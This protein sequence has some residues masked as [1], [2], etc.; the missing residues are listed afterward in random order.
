MAEYAHPNVLVSTDWVQNHNQPGAFRLVEVDVD[1][2]NYNQGHIEGAIGWN[3]ESQLCDGVRRDILTK[4]AFETLMKKSGIANDTPVVLYGDN[5]N[6]FACY[7]FWQMKIYGHQ[8][9]RIMN[10]GRKLWRAQN[11]PGTRE[12][13][14]FSLADYVA[15]EP[16]TSLRAFREDLMVAIRERRIHLVDVRSPDEYTGNVIAPAGL[17]ETAQRG[18]HIP[19]AVNVPWGLAVNDDGTFKSPEALHEIYDSRGVSPYQETI[20][21]CRIGER[22][23][24]TWFILKFLLGYHNVKNYDGSWTEW[25]N[26]VGAPIVTGDKPT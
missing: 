21:Y 14:R 20:T 8:D 11:R 17:T 26:L 7:A 12:I 22:S 13:P 6:W 9:V 18:G 24:H 19:T 2:A 3:W 5:D 15:R 1:T 16:D 23:A 10:G 4:P 25:G